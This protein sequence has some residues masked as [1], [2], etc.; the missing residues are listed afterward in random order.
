[1][2][3]LSACKQEMP[4]TEDS[5]R[6][7]QQQIQ[8][9]KTASG[10]S[11]EVEIV[12][13]GDW[14]VD[15]YTEGVQL[16]LELDTT[17][18]S[19]NGRINLKL[20]ETNP[21]EYKRIAVLTFSCGSASEKLLVEQEPSYG[22]SLE[23]STSSIV[24]AKG[25]SEQSFEVITE[26]S[27][28]IKAED[29]PSWLNLSTTAAEK[30][31]VV[32]ASVT[33]P[34]EDISS[35]S[36]VIPVSIDRVHIAKLTVSQKSSLD[37]SI[38]LD[39]KS[40]TFEGVEPTSTQINV[41]TNTDIYAWTMTGLTASVKEWLDVDIQSAT[42]VQTT[43]T[44]RT[45]QANKTG[46]ERKAYL[47]FSIGE[48]VK[49]SLTVTQQPKPDVLIKYIY[50]CKSTQTIFV[51][52]DASGYTS[53][54]YCAAAACD[55]S[56]PYYDG[57]NG[58]QQF[59]GYIRATRRYILS[60]DEGSNEAQ[61]EIVF[62]NMPSVSGK[63]TYYCNTSSFAFR[64]IRMAYSY[65]LIPAIPGHKLVHIKA[66]CDNAADRGCITISTDNRVDLNTGASSPNVVEGLSMQTIGKPTPF[67]VEL[68]TTEVNTP[69]YFNV[70]SDRYINGFTFTYKQID[71]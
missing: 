10:Q 61:K 66:T 45:L 16:W 50:T 63:V 51:P 18:G 27:W 55:A 21:Y 3:A 26:Q 46:K 64:S 6:L 29:V 24:F 42:G 34:N 30:G 43:V 71:D 60:M 70:V 31:C 1:M 5:I 2:T 54:P 8:F 19:G 47:T 37:I 67:D 32:T 57:K 36:A 23:L 22:R 40:V 33:A 41:I 62:S 9:D 65:I 25:Q 38:S 13:N 59:T 17:S 56:T 52:E 4:Q 14:A 68:T 48:D 12:S 44:L 28:S 20:V 53:F 58:E 35:R 15:G 7:S 49:A 39:P 69:Y 11:S